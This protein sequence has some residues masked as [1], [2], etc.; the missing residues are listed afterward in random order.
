MTVDGHSYVPKG[1][2]A[3]LKSDAVQD[4]EAG[5]SL[6]AVAEKHGVSKTSLSRWHSELRRNGSSS[7]IA[8]L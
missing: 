5:M 1:A 6:A 3:A 2:A 7:P 8:H 4:I